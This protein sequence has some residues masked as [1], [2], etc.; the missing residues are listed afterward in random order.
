MR[1][2]KIVLAIITNANLA[3]GV[4]ALIFIQ[5]KKVSEVLLSNLKR[6]NLLLCRYSLF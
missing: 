6:L 5:K 1:T 3:V 2:P 4:T